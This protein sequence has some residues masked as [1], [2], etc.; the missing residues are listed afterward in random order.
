MGNKIEM[1]QEI[2]DASK[3]NLALMYHQLESIMNRHNKESRSAGPLEG[4]YDDLF[5]LRNRVLRRYAL[6]DAFITAQQ[7]V[8]ED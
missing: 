5:G 8:K 3:A 1:E 7:N 2:D 6:Y 4:K